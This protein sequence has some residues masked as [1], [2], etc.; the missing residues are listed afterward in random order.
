MRRA[1]PSW[2]T[3]MIRVFLAWEAAELVLVGLVA[4]FFTW[5]WAQSCHFLCE[6]KLVFVIA[7]EL[8]TAGVA[9]VA[10]ALA[11]WLRASRLG[12]WLVVL[13]I[14]CALVGAMLMLWDVGVTVFE[15]SRYALYTFQFWAMRPIMLWPSVGAILTLALGLTSIYG[16]WPRALR[17]GWPVACLILSLYFLSY[18]LPATD[19]RVAG[20]HGLGVVRLPGDAVAPGKYDGHRFVPYMDPRLLLN[21][22]YDG[23]LVIANPGDYAVSEYCVDGWRGLGPPKV[24]D[25]RVALGTTTVVPDVCP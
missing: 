2:A 8:A 4:L 12:T 15:P 1:L 16:A 3:A 7:G 14:G 9:L 11:V 19:P 24:V 23:Y 18:L 17:V 25:F 22:G 21:G 6:F 5:D 20:L 13:V 10:L